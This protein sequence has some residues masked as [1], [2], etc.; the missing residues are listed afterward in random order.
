MGEAKVECRKCGASLPSRGYLCKNC[1]TM[2]DKEQIK[3]QK[4]YIKNEEN[5]KIEVNFLSDR[6]RREPVNRN[7]EGHKEQ[8]LLGVLVIIIV[9]FI[10]ILLAILKMI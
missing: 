6:Y 8:K 2:M 5:K 9:L 3:L 1:G 10:L 4:E 7:L